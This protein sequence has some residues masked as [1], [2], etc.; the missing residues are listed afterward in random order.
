MLKIF[1]LDESDSSGFPEHAG[2]FNNRGRG[3][4]RG[5]QRGRGGN[6]RG[7]GFRGSGRGGSNWRGGKFLVLIKFFGFYN[8]YFK[9]E[10]KAPMIETNE[11]E[12]M[13]AAR[14]IETI[15]EDTAAAAV[16]IE[17]NEE[18]LVEVDIVVVA[19]IAAVDIEEDLADHHV[20]TELIALEVVVAVVWVV[21][22]AAVVMFRKTITPSSTVV[23]RNLRIS[24]A[25]CDFLLKYFVCAVLR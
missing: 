17:T 3:G 11:E 8:F 14:T 24:T 22:A 9:E 16:S 4:F 19:N 7:D 13:V 25:T 5:G 6:Y 20:A 2:E 10:T 18:A 23:K 1:A 21:L 15:V 12:V